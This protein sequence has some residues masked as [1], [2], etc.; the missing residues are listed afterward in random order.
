RLEVLE[1]RAVPAVVNWTLGANG[2]FANPLAWT[3][4]SDGSHHIPGP[5]DDAAIP[6]AFTVKSSADE[7][8]HTITAPEL[9]L[10]AGTFTVNA[11]LANAGTIR[12]D[13]GTLAV[14]GTFTQT[15]GLTTI[16]TG[17]VLQTPTLQLT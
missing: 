3:D 7:T 10:L 9:Q 8:V 12:I 5:A 1:G 17:A 14:A 16:A 2:D 11:A 13:G 15:A 4:A 6:G